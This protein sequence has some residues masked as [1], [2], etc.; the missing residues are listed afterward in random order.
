MDYNPIM[1]S[2][3][4]AD[5]DRATGKKRPLPDYIPSDFS[6][7][8]VNP[9]VKRTNRGYIETPIVNMARYGPFPNPGFRQRKRKIRRY[10]RKNY[11]NKV[12]R[13]ITTNPNFSRYK[14]QYVFS[15][16][17]D[18]NDGA[19]LDDTKVCHFQCNTSCLKDVVIQYGTTATFFL[20]SDGTAPA[21]GTNKLYTMVTAASALPA[22]VLAIQDQFMRG[23]VVGVKYKFT[24][25][26]NGQNQ[27]L[28][29]LYGPTPNQALPNRTAMLDGTTWA[30]IAGEKWIKEI[31]LTGPAGSMME[32]S[33]YGYLKNHVTQ[34]VTKQAYKTDNVFDFVVTTQNTR[35]VPTRNAYF[36]IWL[37]ATAENGEL[38][39]P[40]VKI[41]LTMDYY[42]EFFQHRAYSV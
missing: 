22:G 27:N 38:E 6:D 33:R 25:I 12:S 9:E 29:I 36:N 1:S 14:L 5:T 41:A 15:L 35:D 4:T 10:I 23:R 42:Y 31:S 13:Y 21:T 24:I 39:Y 7:I 17:Y 32:T 20:N 40:D 2:L 37:R 28:D 16:R 26:N 3:S 19:S 11:K 8:W 30:R 18:R 34:G